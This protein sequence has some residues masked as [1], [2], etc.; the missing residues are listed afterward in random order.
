M[1]KRDLLSDA[2]PFESV[3]SVRLLDLLLQ[4]KIV[5]QLRTDI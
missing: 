3:V 2:S 4:L 5:M 1:V